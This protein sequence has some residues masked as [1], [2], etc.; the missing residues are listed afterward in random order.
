[1]VSEQVLGNI[2][3]LGAHLWMQPDYIQ[4]LATLTPFSFN[5]AKNSF[6]L[7]EQEG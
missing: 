1:M 4:H 5:A 6:T 7:S 3:I 2:Y